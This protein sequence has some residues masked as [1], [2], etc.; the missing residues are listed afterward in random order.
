MIISHFPSGGGDPSGMPQF[1]YTGT[2]QVDYDSGGWKVKFVTSGRLSMISGA[3]VDIFMVGGGGSGSD[4]NVTTTGQTTGGSTVRQY[5]SKRYG[6]GGGSGYAVTHRQV[7]LVAGQSYDIAVGEAG[8]ATTFNGVNITLAYTANPGQNGGQYT[9]GDGGSG[10]ASGGY[11][12]TYTSGGYF[13]GEKYVAGGKDGSDGSKTMSSI[14]E[15]AVGHGQGSPTREF[16]DADG[17]LYAQGGRATYDASYQQ[18]P[19]PNSGNGGTG[20]QYRAGSSGVVIIRNT[21][22]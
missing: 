14:S 15:Y 22:G 11:Y 18:E 13:S 7:E 9:G 20:G 17:A 2:Y 6:G 10:G 3:T 1:T 8:E 16:G 4:Y 12:S 21:R 5:T 19:V